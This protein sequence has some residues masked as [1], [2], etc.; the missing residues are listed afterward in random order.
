MKT[1]LITDALGAASHAE[2]LSESANIIFTN[3]KIK[4]LNSLLQLSSAGVDISLI[5]LLS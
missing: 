3:S 1:S 5:C 2:E 4:L